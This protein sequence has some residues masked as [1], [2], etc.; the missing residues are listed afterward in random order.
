MEA[1]NDNEDCLAS[2]VTHIEWL[3]SDA[4]KAVCLLKAGIA[5]SF[6]EAYRMV[7]NNFRMVK[8]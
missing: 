5:S 2:T 6:K 1:A 7:D 8:S 3:G 4:Y